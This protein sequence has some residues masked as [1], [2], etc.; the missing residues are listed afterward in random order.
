MAAI[1]NELYVVNEETVVVV[2]ALTV[3]YG[4]LKYGGPAYKEWAEGQIAK[5]KE[6][7]GS[8]R[9]EHTQAV[10]KRI[11]DVKQLSGVV[12]IT[13][14][15]FAVSKETAQ[16]EAEH[17][18]LE[19]R[20]ALAAEA[21]RALDSW[22]NYEAQIKQREQQE[23]ASTVI[24]RISKELQNP[25]VLQQI[26]QQSVTDVESEFSVTDEYPACMLTGQKSSPR[27][28]LLGRV[29]DRWQEVGVK[30]LVCTKNRVILC[31]LSQYFF[32]LFRSCVVY[33]HFLP[34]I[35]PPTARLRLVIHPI[36]N[37]PILDSTSA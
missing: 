7:L 10:A 4:V 30:I 18:E 17:Y 16:L 11:D 1:S 28:K 8:A 23:L 12:D 26:L 6:I 24:S 5:Q 19:Q 25:K 27:N 34:S 14:Q 20:T 9:A 29:A 2:A 22:V 15:L 31:N 13:R 3:F 33:R 35:G 21:K 37:C 32:F 36:V